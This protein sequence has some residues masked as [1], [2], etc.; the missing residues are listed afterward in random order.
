M[1]LILNQ[2]GRIKVSLG[3]GS[4][5]LPPTK[6]ALI[7]GNGSEWVLLE[8][9]PDPATLIA[10]SAESVGV[11]WSTGRWEPMVDNSDPDNPEILF[12]GG[13]VVMGFVEE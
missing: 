7:V 2:S 4:I 13:D 9:G 1:S 10:D 8:V 11:R 5:D 12:E 6:G 3:G